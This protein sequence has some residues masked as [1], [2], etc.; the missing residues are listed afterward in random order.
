MSVLRPGWWVRKASKC[1]A[2]WMAQGAGHRAGLRSFATTRD[3]HDEQL[4]NLIEAVGRGNQEGCAAVVV[5]VLDR[6]DLVWLDACKNGCHGL[7]RAEFG[8]PV[9]GS[10]APF[11]LD[12]DQDAAVDKDGQHVFVA[13]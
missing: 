8:R 2:L 10:A 1:T 5:P 9:D 4:D 7:Q 6:S 11:V 12:A 3:A 13:R